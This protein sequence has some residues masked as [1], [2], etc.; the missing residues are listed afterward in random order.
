MEMSRLGF[1][2]FEWPDRASARA[3]GQIRFLAA[4]RRD[5]P[6]VLDD[7]A[8]EQL[9]LFRAQFCNP[10]PSN[11]AEQQDFLDS[12]ILWWPNF[13]RI[14]ELPRM[15]PELSHL[16]DRLLDWARRWHLD[17]DWC[18][19]AWNGS[20]RVA[21]VSPAGLEQRLVGRRALPLRF[22]HEWFDNT[23]VAVRDMG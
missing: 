22:K 16:R 17:A 18:V 1:G 10:G 7:L 23:G 20:R 6:E 12:G 15:P 13:T 21:A 5:A 4:I 14:T 11:A 3:D 8:G 9:A 2:E 19:P